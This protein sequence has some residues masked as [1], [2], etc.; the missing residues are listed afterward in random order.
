[1]PPLPLRTAALTCFLLIAAGVSAARLALGDPV[2]QVETD[3]KANAAHVRASIDIT[4]APWWCGT[5]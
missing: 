5:Y 4:A 3:D 1:M 2:V